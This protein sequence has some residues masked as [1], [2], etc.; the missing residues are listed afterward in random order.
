MVQEM[1]KEAMLA[2]HEKEAKNLKLLLW[3][4]NIDTKSIFNLT[5]SRK[6]I[7]KFLF[8]SLDIGRGCSF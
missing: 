3:I 8:K 6:V 1:Q 2:D 7:V 5:S 4:W